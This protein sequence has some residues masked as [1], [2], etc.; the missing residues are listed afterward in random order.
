MGHV[1]AKLSLP[2]RINDIIVVAKSIATALASPSFPTP[3]PTLAIL[4]ADIAALEAAEALVL[5]RVKGAVE[6]RDEKLAVVRTDLRYEKAYVQQVADASPAA[7][8]SIIESAGM[9]VK[10]S[11]GH[12]KPDFEVRRGTV[13]GSVRIVARAAG[14]RA[15]YDWEY[16]T[17][18][19]SWTRADP[20]VRADTVL[21]GLK[22]ATRYF[23]RYRPVTNAGVGNWSRVVSL[24]VG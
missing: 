7:A 23:F 20:T 16:G 24:A 15:S 9:S 6:A 10:K 17:D 3:N 5:S 13:S 1:E 21:S 22:S 8:E 11:S 2:K 18:E 12:G 4:Q 19:T 14:T